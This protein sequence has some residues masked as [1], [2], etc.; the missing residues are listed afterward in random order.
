MITMNNIKYLYTLWHQGYLRFVLFAL[1]I[2]AAIISCQQ[3]DI[4]IPDAVNNP[5][6]L[7]SSASELILIEKQANA[8]IEF[9]W[10][11]GSNYGTGASIEYTLVFTEE[12]NTSFKQH[13]G[14][15]VY[16]KVYFY[17]EL[18]E[19]LINEL[20]LDVDKQA[21]VSAK[22]VATI[23]AEGMEADTSDAID[24]K[25]TPYLPVTKKLYIIGS[26]TSAQWDIENAI[27][28]TPDS[29]DP[30]VFLFKG[31]L[32]VGTFKFPVN[33][34]SDF[35]QDMYMKDPADSTKI[36]LHKGEDDDDSQWHI[37]KEG[38][39]E[40]LISL[41]DL[42]IDIKMLEG[43]AYD[44]LYIIGDATTAGWDIASAPEVIQNPDNLFEFVF[45][46]LLVPG[47]F[48]FPVNKQSDFLQDMFMRDPADSTKIYLHKGGDDDDNKWTI[49][50]EGWYRIILNLAE[51]TISIESLELYIIGS[52]TSV[53]WDI[54]N[55]IPLIKN[56]SEPFKYHFEGNLLE[57][58]FK[59][60]V[61]RQ[62][63]WQQDMYMRDPDDATK[64]YRHKGGDDDDNKWN[65]T[66]AGIYSITVNVKDLSIDIIKQ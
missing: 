15:A 44:V 50:Q 61:N 4:V 47:E 40:I 32:S 27:E 7:N 46:G 54:A 10:T 45:D 6:V 17:S 29:E 16:S 31:A 18:N 55:A 24:L 9:T 21:T 57:G 14:K 5:L 65:I 48:K 51:N 36:Y 56:E 59:F 12:S 58:E 63:D 41:L 2:S 28:L 66:E 34:Q 30:T 26:A 43:P 8:T 23:N 35:M 53:G 64:I 20:G 11:S 62:T 42:T 37:S 49:T 19:I 22:M 25:I 60:P 1:A 52:A 3:D 39:Y 33:K 38:Q 13:L